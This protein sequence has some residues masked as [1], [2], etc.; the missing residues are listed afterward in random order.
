MVACSC[1]QGIQCQTNVGVCLSCLPS[2][3]NRNFQFS[4]P[5][6][7]DVKLF[8]PF[9]STNT[10]IRVCSKTSHPPHLSLISSLISHPSFLSF[11]FTFFRSSLPPPFSLISIP[12]LVTSFRCLTLICYTSNLVVTISFVL[13]E[14]FL[15]QEKLT[16]SSPKSRIL[17]RGR[18]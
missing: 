8:F 10:M 12:Q 7:S 13:I 14:V 6:N 2:V 18:A 3:D 17:E 5:F 4:S 1:C 15:M 16:A 9:R 11:F